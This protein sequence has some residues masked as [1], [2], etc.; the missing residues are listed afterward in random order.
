MRVWMILCVCF[1]LISFAMLAAAIVLLRAWRLRFLDAA[2]IA[3]DLGTACGIMHSASQ[4]LCT[5][6]RD[7]YARILLGQSA[8]SMLLCRNICTL[9]QQKRVKTLQLH[10]DDVSECI[11]QCCNA[12]QDYLLVHDVH[13]VY[14]YR[15]SCMARFDALALQR[16]VQNLVVNAFEAMPDGGYIHVLVDGQADAGSITIVVQDDGRGMQEETL[17][18]IFL[19]HATSKEDTLCHGLGLPAALRLAKL[20]RGT[21]TAKSEVGTGTSLIFSFPR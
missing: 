13:L 2:G 6:D 19:K 17:K 3:H 9:L 16:I 14:E 21:L 7:T 10:L 11:R 4:M 5:K 8:Y 12:L 15:G 18:K 20:H 1:M